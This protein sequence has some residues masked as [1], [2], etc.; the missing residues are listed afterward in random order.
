MGQ[1][2]IFLKKKRP[3]FARRE[4]DAMIRV[5]VKLHTKHFD[6]VR[7]AI[8]RGECKD[9]GVSEVICSCLLSVVKQV[10]DF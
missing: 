9:V 10:R 6:Q 7:K 3:Q 5:N 4:P 8:D 1:L 2:S